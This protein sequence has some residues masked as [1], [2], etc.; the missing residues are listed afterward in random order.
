M[1]EFLN[2]M[3]NH[4][5]AFIQR[6]SSG[7][8]NLCMQAVHARAEGY[9]CIGIVHLPG[10]VP[11]DRNEIMFAQMRQQLRQHI[12]GV[13]KMDGRAC[14]KGGHHEISCDCPTAQPSAATASTSTKGR[15]C[16]QVRT[17][18]RTPHTSRNRASV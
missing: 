17:R 16:S 4:H 18:A 8:G 14:L 13:T 1:A 7:C 6:C 3:K 10:I 9:F 11:A 15:P 12:V 5:F 2:M